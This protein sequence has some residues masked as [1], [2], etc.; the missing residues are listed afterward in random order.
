MTIGAVF[1]SYVLA[2]ALIT[3]TFFEILPWLAR[4]YPRFAP[5]SFVDVILDAR[6]LIVLAAIAAGL[7]MRERD[8][9]TEIARVSVIVTVAMYAALL[10]QGKGWGY[11]WYPVV[12]TALIACAI[13]ARPLAKPPGISESVEWANAATV[14]EKGGSPWPEAFRRAIGVLI[15]DEEDLAL[16]RGELPRILEEALG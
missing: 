14:L 13:R 9:W 16:M 2:T 11:H 6:A 5:T 12:G 8:V 4:L 10:M 1:V 3:P 7:S 15:K